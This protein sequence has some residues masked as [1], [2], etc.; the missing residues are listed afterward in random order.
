MGRPREYDPDTVLDRAVDVFWRKGFQGTSV[1]ELVDA[2]GINRASMYGGYGSKE[3]L[4]QAALERYIEA[5]SL[6]EALDADDDTPFVQL[7]R[8]MFDELVDIGSSD[9]DLRGCFVTNTAVEMGPHD[10]AANHAVGDSF[11]QLEGA[12][13]RRIRRAQHKGEI[14]IGIDNVALARFIITSM[15]GIRVLSRL[16]NDRRYLQDIA[17]MVVLT[18]S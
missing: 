10:P 7:V 3:G 15:Q 11:D 18:F 6:V 5:G 17:D 1:Q 2:T 14:D 13:A 8:A 12:L 9:P 16:R 4:F